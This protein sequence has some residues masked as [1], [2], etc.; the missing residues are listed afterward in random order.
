MKRV[1]IDRS[2]YSDDT[3]EKTRQVYKNYAITSLRYKRDYVE[4]IFWKCQYDEAQTIKEF[5]NYMI[6]VENS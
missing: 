2:I 5:E 6:G 3:I 4:I 1:R